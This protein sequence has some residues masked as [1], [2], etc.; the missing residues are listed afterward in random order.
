M[1]TFSKSFLTFENTMQI[2]PKKV[3]IGEGVYFG[4]CVLP[5]NNPVSLLNNRL[6]VHKYRSRFTVW[7]ITLRANSFSTY[8]YTYRI[9]Y[10]YPVSNKCVD[11]P[12]SPKAVYCSV[13]CFQ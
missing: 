8:T 12:K 3:L 4:M 2:D 6:K 13:Y 11:N 10:V 1:E 9:S 5:T 7:I